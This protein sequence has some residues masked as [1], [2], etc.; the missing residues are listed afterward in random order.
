MLFV[1]SIAWLLIA[2]I[3]APRH[4]LIRI[5]PESGE[6]AWVLTLVARQVS[7]VLPRRRALR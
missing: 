2:D 7:V 6:V 5:S 1:I 4:G 3:D